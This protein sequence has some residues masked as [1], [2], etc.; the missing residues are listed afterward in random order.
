MLAKLY[1]PGRTYVISPFTITYY[2]LLPT[3]W[4]RLLLVTITR[5]NRFTLSHF[6]SHT[7]LS[8]LKSHVTISIPRLGTGCW[9][10]FT[11]Q[12]S[13]LLYIKHLTGALCVQ[14]QRLQGHD[15]FA[16]TLSYHILLKL[17][18]YSN[19]IFKTCN[20]NVIFLILRFFYFHSTNSFGKVLKLYPSE[21]EAFIL[22]CV[23]K[24]HTLPMTKAQ[25]LRE[26][27]SHRG[28]HRNCD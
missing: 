27:Q 17:Y 28:R 10:N 22:L 21:I 6:G 7:P 13:H 24:W 5:L 25:A 18:H 1:D 8:T 11:R 23:S 12:A 26:S 14:P 2:C 3:Q 9:L 20:T 19:K 16:F 4:H 15:S